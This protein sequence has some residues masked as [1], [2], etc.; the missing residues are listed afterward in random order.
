MCIINSSTTKY[1]RIL[2]LERVLATRV[3]TY[4]QSGVLFF[5]IR[6]KWEH[7]VLFDFRVR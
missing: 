7:R 2:S 6:A 5:S 3:L 1:E 4:R